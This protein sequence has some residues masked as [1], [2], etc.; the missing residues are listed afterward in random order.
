ME[1]LCLEVEQ[2]RRLVSFVHDTSLSILYPAGL[3][4]QGRR[5]WILPAK[6]LTM[7]TPGS[8]AH[9]ELQPSDIDH[10]RKDL[11]DSLPNL[12]P[13]LAI[14]T[15][16]HQDTHCTTQKNNVGID[17]GVRWT[18]PLTV[19]CLDHI[20]TPDPTHSAKL[21]RCSLLPRPRLP[22]HVPSR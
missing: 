20:A 11:H 16:G 17:Q 14:A 4:Q 21:C 7:T 6:I 9:E 2:R 1:V 12:L 13:R 15:S 18:H 3:A 5:R 10:Q 19:I 8:E 22:Q